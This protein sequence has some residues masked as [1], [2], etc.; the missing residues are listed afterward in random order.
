MERFRECMVCVW[1]PK[2]SN[3]QQNVIRKSIH[4]HS[5]SIHSEFSFLVQSNFVSGCN[6]KSLRKHSSRM[7]STVNDIPSG[8]QLSK[9]PTSKDL[10]P[11]TFTLT[12]IF[13]MIFDG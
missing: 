1:L 11:E 4:C 5:Y 10:C 12:V 13:F 9:N 8:M 7:N 2:C 6:R 3:I